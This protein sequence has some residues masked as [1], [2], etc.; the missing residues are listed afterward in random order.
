MRATLST[1]TQDDALDMAEDP[2]VVVVD[3]R[4]WS[5][6]LGWSTDSSPGGHLA[7]AVHLPLAGVRGWPDVALRRAV[8][9]KDMDRRR[10]HLV[11]DSGNGEAALVSD[12]LRL[13]GWQRVHWTRLCMTDCAREGAKP[14]VRLSR[15]HRQVPG[16][17]VRQ[18]MAGVTC[19]RPPRREVVVVCA[20]WRAEQRYLAGHIPGAVYLD[21][22]S[23]ESPPRWNRR[24]RA[25]LREQLRRHGITAD[26]T[27]VLY[28]HHVGAVARAALLCTHAGVG[29][30]RILGGGTDA[31][32]ASGGCLD[33]GHVTPLRPTSFGEPTTGAPCVID[34]AQAE[35]LAVSQ[36]GRLVD[37]R[38]WREHIGRTPGYADLAGRRGRIPGDWFGGDRCARSAEAALTCPDGQPRN[39]LEVVGVWSGRDIKQS[40]DVAF[41]CGTGWRASVA[42]WVAGL[43]GWDARVFDGGWREWSSDP[44]RPIVRGWRRL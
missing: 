27:V 44:M 14:L 24:P 4:S 18:V 26:R 15:F 33:R 34:L 10:T 29:D 2:D 25:V 11:Y 7:G 28:G 5:Q 3:A 36:H 16:T 22:E 21:T 41:Y 12:W 20:G 38:S 30:V 23:L 35:R 9:N 39:P 8:G 13:H 42:W 1:V 19:E 6:V 37:V 17:W 31:W 40:H 43:A 32:T